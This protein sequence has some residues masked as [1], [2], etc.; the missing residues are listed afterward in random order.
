MRSLRLV[1]LVP[2]ADTGEY[3]SCLV[4][5]GCAA[6]RPRLARD[7]LACVLA[8]PWYTYAIVGYRFFLGWKT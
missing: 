1:S 8:L 7:L 5:L 2:V 6:L 4:G 3:L